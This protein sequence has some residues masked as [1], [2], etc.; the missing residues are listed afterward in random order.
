MNFYHTFLITSCSVVY[1]FTLY[2]TWETG[3]GYRIF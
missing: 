2:L 3:R 1:M